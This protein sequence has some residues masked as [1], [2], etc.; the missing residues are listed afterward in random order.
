MTTRDSSGLIFDASSQIP[1]VSASAHSQPVPSMSG[2]LS[3][4]G[5]G[6]GR[7]EIRLWERQ[8]RALLDYAAWWL[9][10]PERAMLCSRLGVE[11]TA[12]RVESPPIE[13]TARREFGRSAR[14]SDLHEH[15]E[16]IVERAVR[17][18]AEKL[19]TKISSGPVLE[20][21]GGWSSYCRRTTR[22]EVKRGISAVVKTRSG[23][24]RPSRA[25]SVDLDYL[26]YRER[27]HVPSAE[28]VVRVWAPGYRSRTTG[29]L[30]HREDLASW[31]A[32]EGAGA[33]LV[34]SDRIMVGHRGPEEETILSAPRR[35][36]RVENLHPRRALHVVVGVRAPSVDG[37][38]EHHST[39]LHT[40][41]GF[42]L[43]PDHLGGG[44]GALQ[45]DRTP[46]GRDLDSFL[47]E[48]GRCLQQLMSDRSWRIDGRR[49]REGSK[50]EAVR[51]VDALRQGHA[52]GLMAVLCTLPGVGCGAPGGPQAARE[53]RNFMS[54]AARRAWPGDSAAQVQRRSR[55]RRLT[56]ALL[57]DASRSAHRLP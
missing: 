56:E 34:N 5:D 47:H 21:R 30:V 25:E 33:L 55:L 9:P 31:E 15:L 7:D 39:L 44:S 41:R 29:A 42:G 12:P 23:R 50:Q 54:D 14:G 51:F 27:F 20:L 10:V 36:L 13:G 4:A 8:L 49:P 40:Q 28:M 22:N 6:F 52:S 35:V 53:G 1:L 48:V 17:A 3:P 38:L 43:S 16:S 57:S 46:C 45:V 18:A 19:L 2:E 37:A 32:A 26:T 24:L 11:D